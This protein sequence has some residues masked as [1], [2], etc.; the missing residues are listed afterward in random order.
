MTEVP[1]R[2]VQA[3]RL[4]DVE[5]GERV[6]WDWRKDQSVA[7]SQQEIEEA[8]VAIGSLGSDGGDCHGE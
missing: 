7:E 6:H 2:F 5:T 1:I 3:S 4:Y 8:L